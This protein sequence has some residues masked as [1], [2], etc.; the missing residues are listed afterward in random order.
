[1]NIPS[2]GSISIKKKNIQNHNL[3]NTKLLKIVELQ[4][5]LSNGKKQ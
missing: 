2:M 5:V 4:K 1:M 3:M